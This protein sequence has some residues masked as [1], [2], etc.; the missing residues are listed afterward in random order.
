MAK[1]SGGGPGLAGEVGKASHGTAAKPSPAQDFADT[2][3]ADPQLPGDVTGPHTLVGQLH[4]ALPH[5]VG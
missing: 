2:A 5:H 4:D 3:V 1:S